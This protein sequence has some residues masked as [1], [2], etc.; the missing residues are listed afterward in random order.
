[1]KLDK[2]VWLA[3][4]AVAIVFNGWSATQNGK[5]SLKNRQI[6]FNIA[7]GSAGQV[8]LSY[9]LNGKTY[10]AVTLQPSMKGAKDKL[11]YTVTLSG[12]DKQS[13]TLTF[14]SANRYR[15]SLQFTFG[16]PQNYLKLTK[17][18]N[19]SN[20][21]INF[22]SAAFVLPD[23]RSEDLV[24]YP[25]DW[26]QNSL[27]IPND[28][29]LVLNMLDN[30]S[31]MLSCLWNSTTIKLT[32]RKAANGKSFS[33]MDLQPKRGDTIWLGLNVAK[34]IW[35]I[36]TKTITTKPIP[37]RW[38]PP[39]SAVWQVSIKKGKSKLHAENG[40]CDSW[41]LADL[42]AKRPKSGRA[43]VG[44]QNQDGKTW[45]SS[46]GGYVY[47]FFLKNGKVFL[48]FPKYNSRRMT[49]DEKF[50]P[51]I[52]PVESQKKQPS[53]QILPYDVLAKVLAAKTFTTLSNVRSKKSNYP[54]TCGITEKVE[55]IFYRDA[56][57]KSKD[58]IKNYFKRMNSFVRYNRERI[59]EY[60]KWSNKINKQLKAYGKKNPTAAKLT[61]SLNKDL[62]QIKLYYAAVRDKIKTPQYCKMLTDKVEKL[63]GSS[64][65]AETQEEACKDIGRQIRVIGGKQDHLVADLRYITKAFRMRVTLALLE[66]PPPVQREILEKMR[67]ETARIMHLRFPMEGK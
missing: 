13:G 24:I 40:Q 53:G 7:S 8:T 45:T 25:T 16:T 3:A 11:S 60:D 9:L 50:R 52:Y 65:D 32:E 56:A 35:T 34:N 54:A 44:I 41:Q 31:A 46:L 55:K 63:I 47:P 14:T 6:A 19:V 2:K 10:P 38:E 66:N 59:L 57:E 48:N 58:I 29:H 27:S 23:Q 12:S 4:A 39:F 51:L 15:G 30:G 21:K 18:T 5:F 67:S 64:K 36:P 62:Y 43:G 49:Y 33:G 1:M 26:K 28:N 22:K 37:L 61:K 17:F 20:L 42:D